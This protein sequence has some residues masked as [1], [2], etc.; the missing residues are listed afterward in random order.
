LLT[1]VLVLATSPL[2]AHGE[3]ISQTPM[4]EL[5]SR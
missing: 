4:A 2:T 3:M 1:I 5:R